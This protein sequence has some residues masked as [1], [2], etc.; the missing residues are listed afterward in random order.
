MQGLKV[1]W[2]LCFDMRFPAGGVTCCRTEREARRESLEGLDVRLMFTS[3]QTAVSMVTDS[4]TCLDHSGAIIKAWL[5]T[6][7]VMHLSCILH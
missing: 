2:A 5:V 3:G 6:L 1:S 7:L 4:V